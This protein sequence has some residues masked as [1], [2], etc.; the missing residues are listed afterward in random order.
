[1]S[2]SSTKC[3]QTLFVQDVSSEI[4]PTSEERSLD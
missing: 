4:C 3:L 2:T 1:V